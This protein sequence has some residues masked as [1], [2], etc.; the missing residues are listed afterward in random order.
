MNN[1]QALN[2]SCHDKERL[3]LE[4]IIKNVVAQTVRDMKS[5]AG[6]EQDY[7]ALL[8][9]DIRDMLNVYHAEFQNLRSEIRSLMTST[10]T[11]KKAKHSKTA[12]KGC[13][14]TPHV[15][16]PWC[17]DSSLQGK[18][19]VADE[20]GDAPESATDTNPYAEPDVVENS[21]HH[22]QFKESSTQYAS[23]LVT[24]AATGTRPTIHKSMRG[25][26]MALGA[27]HGW[28]A[29]R[30]NVL[31]SNLLAKVDSA[32]F[33]MS[34]DQ[35]AATSLPQ[36]ITKSTLFNAL[37]AIAITAN[38]ILLGTAAD[39]KARR[40][41]EDHLQDA[42]T[43]NGPWTVV[44]NVFTVFFLFELVLRIVAD[45]TSF[46]KSEARVWNM[47]D[48][49]VVSV[50]CI[51]MVVTMVGDTF[52]N[53]SFLRI[54][55]A[56]RLVR[57]VKLFRVVRFFRELRVMVYSI[58][59]CVN[60]L[61]SAL[62]LL[63]LVMYVFGVFITQHIAEFLAGK[64][65]MPDNIY[66]NDGMLD[67][68]MIRFGTLGR[69]MMSL[70]QAV[71]GGISW[72]ELCAALMSTTEE[73]IFMG[74]FFSA[75]MAFSGLA[76]LNILTGI[77]VDNAMK[78]TMQDKDMVIHDEM[79]RERSYMNEVKRMFEEADLDR[80]GEL[81]WSE[82][83]TYLEDE[84]VQAYFNSLDLD[85]AAAKGLFKLLDTDGSG[86]VSCEEFVLGCARL[87]GG[88]RSVDVATLLYENKKLMHQL[89]KF[90]SCCMAELR[91]V[92]TL[93]EQVDDHVLKLDQ[94]EESSTL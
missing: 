67:F 57:I 26:I 84:R 19:R 61:I 43:S 77:F 46:F 72:G 22:V 91:D 4:D 27:I 14:Q 32:A 1:L 17:Y 3:A 11:S 30:T 58:L 8:K 44:E 50:G 47:F 16:E 59:E 18:P 55:R 64:E 81:S 85:P 80:S 75:F 33:T 25:N 6:P 7:N 39:Q 56:L 48:L 63:A 73:P 71:T 45:K 13:S 29:D 89:S 60:S 10:G 41:G 42:C 69:T 28:V 23:L 74:I 92:L 5:Q 36:R 12:S 78:A 83:E 52:I 62:A 88:A 68:I 38:S 34:G 2:C 79:A 40:C 20:R 35:L 49:F 51:D 31:R 87:K 53:I 15:Q 82:L 9:K 66:W 94:R 76:L 65:Q 54:L 93:E 21:E 90:I 37:C 24:Q 86:F 70:Y